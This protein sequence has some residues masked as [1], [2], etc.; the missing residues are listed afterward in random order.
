MNWWKDCSTKSMKMT[1]KYCRWRNASTISVHYSQYIT[2]T[3]D[4]VLEI[5]L[6]KSAESHV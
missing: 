5:K 6:N 4:T 1:L 2:D 3:V